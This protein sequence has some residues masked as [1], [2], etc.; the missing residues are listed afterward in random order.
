MGAIARL[1]LQHAVTAGGQ[2]LVR[3]EVLRGK[4]RNSLERPEPF[5]PGLPTTVE[6]ALND[7]FHAFRKGHRLTVQV[8]SSWFPLMDRNPQVFMDIF[9]AKVEDFKPARHR[10]YHSA[11]LPSYLE[12]PILEP[13]LGSAHPY[14]E[15]W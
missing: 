7:I 10:L 3:G 5:T 8:Q 12:L 4:F 13:H 2:Q 9:S 11:T 6:W 15:G 14:S 1:G